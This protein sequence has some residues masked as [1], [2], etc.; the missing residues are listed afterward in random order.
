M[1]LKGGNAVDAAI[2]AAAALTI[3]EPVSQRPGQRPVRDPVGRRALH[4][5][6]AS[7]V[8]PAAWDPAYF[9]RRHGGALPLRGWDSVTDAGRRRRLG[10][11][12]AALRPAAVRR[13]AGAGHRA[14]RARPWRR[15]HRGRQVGA[16][17]AAAGLAAGLRRGLHAAR[18]RAGGRRA[19]RVR[20]RPARTLRRH[21]RDPGRGVLS[22]RARGGARRA[23][24]GQRRRAD[25]RAIWRNYQ[26]EWVETIAHR[27]RRPHRAR[28][29]AQ[30]PGHRGA[31]GA[32]HAREAGRGALC[33][34]TASRRSTCRSRR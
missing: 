20:G 5:L 2:A 13:P 25:A 6:N 11:A 10:G 28:D 24:G 30:R 12:V 22:R 31:D 8:A 14:G 21:R 4:G 29:P 23:C 16:P 9:A 32:R 19:L 18:P 33:R 26:P 17:G 7:G 27:L 1:L 3:V 34:S 15:L